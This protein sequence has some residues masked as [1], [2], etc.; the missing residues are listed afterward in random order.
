MLILAPC[1][2]HKFLPTSFQKHRLK[3]LC[4]VCCITS[5]QSLLNPFLSGFWL[6]ACEKAFTSLQLTESSHIVK[7]CLP[8]S[9]L[10]LFILSAKPM[11]VYQQILLITFCL[12]GSGVLLSSGFLSHSLEMLRHSNW[13]NCISL[14]SK[15]DSNR[16]FMYLRVLLFFYSFFW[17][18]G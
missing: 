7:F 8:F 14:T 17:L 5:F 13:P 18:S 4:A 9:I 11:N 2:L 6:P 1:R 15:H 10:I 3:V 12:T 16:E